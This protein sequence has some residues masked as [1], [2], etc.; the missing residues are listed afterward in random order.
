MNECVES[1]EWMNVMDN[2][3]RKRE[4]P[5]KFDTNYELICDVMCE[6]KEN[7]TRR[8]EI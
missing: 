1:H 3:R 7:K 2:K 6:H 8:L 4:N 5:L